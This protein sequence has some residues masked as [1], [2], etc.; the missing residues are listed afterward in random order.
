MRCYAIQCF[1]V[2]LLRSKMAVRRLEAA[3]PANELQASATLFLFFKLGAS[4]LQPTSI[5]A[6]VSC[7]CQVVLLSHKVNAWVLEVIKTM[8]TKGW[9]CT[10][11]ANM[12][13]GKMYGIPNR[14]NVDYSSPRFFFSN[15]GSSKEIEFHVCARLCGVEGRGKSLSS[16][17]PNCT[18]QT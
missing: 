5:G 11:R 17:R 9:G 3:A 10:T 15:K 16:H 6:S 18:N 14:P 8:R 13:N 1:Y 2:E 7:P 4:Q 12:K